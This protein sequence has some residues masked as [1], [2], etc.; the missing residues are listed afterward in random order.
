MSQVSREGVPAVRLDVLGK[1]FQQRGHN[2]R[3][4]EGISSAIR[5]GETLGLVGESGKHS[6]AASRGSPRISAVPRC[7]ELEP[8]LA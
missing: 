6:G 7:R 1:V 8:T 2:V 5:P 4:L 3:A